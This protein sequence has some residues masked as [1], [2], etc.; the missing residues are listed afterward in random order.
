M[1]SGNFENWPHYDWQQGVGANQTSQAQL[2]NGLLMTNPY[3]WTEVLQDIA[4]YWE[5]SNDF[6]RYIFYLHEGVKFHDGVE[7]DA[8]TFRYSLERI[9][10][11]GVFPD[12]PGNET[13]PACHST[14]L[15]RFVEGFEA[16]ERYTF[17]VN[18]KGP[19]AF[20]VDLLSSGYYSV[21]PKHI[22][23]RDR[24]NELKDDLRPIGTGPF[25]MAGD[26]SPTLWV[27]D[28]NP[29]YFKPGLPFLDGVE[30]HLILDTQTRAT[31]VVTERIFMNHATSAPFLPFETAKALANNDPG[32]VH[33]HVPSWLFMFWAFNIRDNPLL[34]DIR[35][36]LALSLA[37]DRS[38]LVAEDPFRGTEG[39]GRVRGVVG[40]S[41]FPESPWAP[42]L[43]VIQNY[44]GYGPDMDARRAEARE[45]IADYEAENGPIDW[46]DAPYHCATNHPSCD[47]ATLIQD[48]VKKIG[49]D[50]VLQP[51]EII[52]S[53][54]K[55]VDGDY[56]MGGMYGLLDFDDPTSYPTNHWLQRG[57][58]A[59]SRRVVVE[60]EKLYEE[61]LFLTDQDERKG[62]AWEIDRLFMEDASMNVMWWAIAENLRRDYVKGWSG[63]PDGWG[64][65]ARMDHF[66]LD[67]PELPFA[68]SG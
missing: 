58:W 50:L 57:Q 38:Q 14:I 52:T 19:N 20:I 35:I 15:D 28:R 43:E 29:D 25:R 59:F 66:F 16:P 53:W 18:T 62:V 32:M 2:M 47:N 39:L 68:V 34:S 65:N 5:V 49:V 31:A 51:G 17:V 33:S 9:R 4:Y 3:E 56:A 61:S 36:R 11:K 44:T 60:A 67:L 13:C 48:Q 54:Q 22:N 42:P 24:K 45:L 40:T 46:G 10:S 7:V 8:E 30:V 12:D 23:E 27:E 6:T 21:I 37:V 55:L 41:I 63:N 1:R 26:A 64:T